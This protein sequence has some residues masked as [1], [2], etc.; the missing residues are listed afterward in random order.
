ME[1]SIKLLEANRV[2]SPVRCSSKPLPPI[3]LETDNTDGMSKGSSHMFLE[4]SKV[5]VEESMKHLLTEAQTVEAKIHRGIEVLWQRM[6]DL[7]EHKSQE[8]QQQV[9]S[10]KEELSESE[11]KLSRLSAQEAALVQQSAKASTQLTKEERKRKDLEQS[12]SG[13]QAK[14]DASQKELNALTLHFKDREK[15]Q[16]EEVQKLQSQLEEKTSA[17]KDYQMKIKQLTEKMNLLTKDLTHEKS[18]SEKQHRNTSDQLAQQTSEN[19]KLMLEISKL[20]GTLASTVSSL[21][22]CKEE[23]KKLEQALHLQEQDHEITIGRMNKKH[24]SVTKE[25]EEQIAALKKELELLNKQYAIDAE[26]YKQQ[27]MENE[28]EL[29]TLRAL[30]KNSNSDS[31]L[32]ARIQFLRHQNLQEI[33]LQQ[34]RKSNRK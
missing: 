8:M 1:G 12:I 13:L 34:D 26:F 17:L 7:L 20:K 33:K 5:E 16:K 27:L 32:E 31:Y 4:Q 30:A 22:A 10:L 2:L 28:K 3:A 15:A 6:Q 9:T 11:G 14:L 25:L 19:R 21:T 18:S 24:A 29:A 23:K